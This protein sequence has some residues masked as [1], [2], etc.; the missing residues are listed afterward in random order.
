M[1]MAADYLLCNI[2]WG[3]MQTNQVH[4]LVVFPWGTQ[5]QEIHV[6]GLSHATRSLQGIH[7]LWVQAQ[8]SALLTQK[9]RYGKAEFMSYLRGIKI[10]GTADFSHELCI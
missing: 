5:A 10:K 3:W 2:L 8:H 9:I 7:F 6:Q 4:E 1:R